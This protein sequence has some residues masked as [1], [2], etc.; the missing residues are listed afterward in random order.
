[1]NLVLLYDRLKNKIKA[2]Y[3]K[4]VFKTKI[5]CKHNNFIL[6]G[7]VILINKN[8]VLGEGVTIYP[9]CMF[10]G[11]GPIQIGNNV[12]IGNGTI[13]YASMGAGVTIGQ[14]TMIAAQNYIIDTNH[15]M[16]NGE[17]IRD[18]RNICEKVVIGKDCWLGA[19]VTVLKGA[20]IDDGAVVG[21]KAM[22][23]CY[24]EK[25]SISVGIPA[26]VIKYRQ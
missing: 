11:D 3:R 16:R 20:S 25:N 17:K 12:E 18:Q 24:L 5:K 22:V 26:R 4:Y 10:F 8:I 2:S 23:N 9:G 7:D 14:D 15:G 21:A 6:V 19:N 13:I 1:M